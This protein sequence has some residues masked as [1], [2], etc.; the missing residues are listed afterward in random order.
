MGTEGGGLV[1]FDGE[2]WTVYNTKNSGLP[3]N[4]AED[5]LA[6]DSHGTIWV[7]TRGGLAKFDKE[8]WTVYNTENSGLPANH[9]WS[10]ALD[11]HENLWIGTADGG[12]AVYREGGVILESVGE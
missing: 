5:G 10:L 9:I 12:L 1:Q 8:T 7:G 2:T 4:D 6:I 11:R 3:S